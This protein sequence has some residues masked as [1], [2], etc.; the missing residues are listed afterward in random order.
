MFSS[1]E[2]SLL[3]ELVEKYLNNLDTSLTR[4]CIESR[5]RAWDSITEEFN[6]ANVNDIPRDQLELKTKYKNLKAQRVNFKS[7]KMEKSV[8]VVAEQQS[9]NETD[10]I[11]EHRKLR[12]NVPTRQKKSNEAILDS[13]DDDWDYTDDDEDVSSFYL[14][15]DR[16]YLRLLS[17]MFYQ[18]ARHSQLSSKANNTRHQKTKR[19]SEFERK[20]FC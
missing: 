11:I 14:P 2:T 9:S 3:Q 10:P 17:S 5:N 4:D 18:S 7:E 6:W 19:W 16:D 8:A 20:T 15:F 12:V 1:E 13:L